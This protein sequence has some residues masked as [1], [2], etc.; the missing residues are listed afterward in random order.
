V[1]P[2][3]TVALLAAILR[4]RPSLPGALCAGQ[5]PRFDRKALDGET[6]ANR[7]ERLRVSRWVCQRCPVADAC[8]DPVV[9]VP[10]AR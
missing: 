9:R 10:R 1:T 8:P 2:D 6:P 5:A 7:A 3:G 4:D